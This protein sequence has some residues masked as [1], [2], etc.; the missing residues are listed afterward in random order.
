MEGLLIPITLF[1]GLTLVFSLYF[2]FR[3]KS[4]SEMQKTI[5]TALDKGQE[6]SPEIIDRLGTPKPP[7]DKDLRTALVWF[8]LAVSFV[9]LGFGIPEDDEEVLRIMS[10]I[11]AFPFSLGVAYLTMWIYSGRK[12]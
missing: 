9:G 5:R 6:L 7:K 4:R 8:A 3:H 10:G 1:V 11:A 12:S 2:M